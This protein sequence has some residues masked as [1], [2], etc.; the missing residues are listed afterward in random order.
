MTQ[1]VNKHLLARLSSDYGILGVLVLLCAYF[2]WATLQE[3]HPTG[4]AAAKAAAKTVFRSLSKTSKLMIV[5]KTVAHDN[6]FAVAL[7]SL[8]KVAGYK[9]SAVLQGDPAEVRQALQALADSGIVLDAIVTTHDYA[10]AVQ[11]LVMRF[12]ALA[13]TK[14]FIAESYRWP[15]FLLRENLIN[16][17]NQIAVIAIMAIGMTMVI[18]TG[19]IDLSVGSVVALAAVVATRLIVSWGG[20]EASAATMIAAAMLAIVACG[21]LGAACGFFI[22]RF[23]LPPFIATLA[24]MLVASGLAYIIAGG[25]S[26]YDLPNSFVWLG[27]GADLFAIP[28]AV[29]LMFLLYLL[30]NF[31]MGHTVF[32]RHIYAVG[33]NVE[34]ARFS[35][36]SIKK[37]LLWVYTISGAMAGLGGII[38]ASQ[39]KSGAPTYGVMYELYVIAAVVVGG[40][41]LSGGEGKIFGTLIGALIIAVIQNGMNLT[42]VESYTQKVVLGLVILGA[43]LLDKL[44]RMGKLFNRRS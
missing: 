10:H 21:V 38:L 34:A 24:W 7:D 3:Q 28:N 16:V 27:R 44:R 11:N 43:V 15:T 18:V 25:E 36:I 1:H 39:L 22:T 12:P 2:S 32:G 42:G 13:A 6:E 29:V 31:V 17:L 35:G 19:G 9:T 20:T 26:I 8:F 40:A 4:E 37:N 14:V 33:G 23:N 5:T 30:A 41:S